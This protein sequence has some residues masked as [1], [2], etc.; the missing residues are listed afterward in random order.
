VALERLR[1]GTRGSRLA[2]WQA[3]R[4]LGLLRGRYPDLEVERVVIE[5]VGDRVLDKALSKIGDKGLFTA[6]LEEALR[7]RRID[8]AVHSLKDLPTELP[9]DLALGAVLE[10]EDPRDALV[11]RHGEPFAQLP[12]GARVGTS[13]LRRRAQVRAARPGL[14]VRDLRGNVPTRLE[15]VERGEVDA[16]ILALAGLRRLGLEARVTEVLEPERML[17]APGQGALAIERRAGDD[18]VAARLAPFDDPAA[19]LATA[20]ER[21]L[22]A[23]L[24]GGCQ[25]PVG[26]LASPTAGGLR[27]EGLVA[28]PEGGRVLREAIEG[29]PAD[30][31]ESAA[32][33]RT[34]AERLLARGADAILAALRDTPGARA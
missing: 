18:A 21:A 15:K 33:G 32:L 28:D 23:R 34:L 29:T 22:L 26:A 16:A 13:S 10:R 25:V 27:L 9:D 3:D 2:L 5:T 31:G 24:E 14:A 11:S 7:A 1:I 4:V 17:P 19:R 12:D 20:A 30:A 8:V 6:E